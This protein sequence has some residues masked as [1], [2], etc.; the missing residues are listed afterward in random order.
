M[1]VLCDNELGELLNNNGQHMPV[2]EVNMNAI[3]TELVKEDKN[4]EVVH[5]GEDGLVELGS[6]SSETR[7]SPM[8]FYW[9][10][11]VNGLTFG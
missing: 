3:P 5:E 7:G 8:G 6:V 11:G 2:E 9:D 1:S 4:T 10:G